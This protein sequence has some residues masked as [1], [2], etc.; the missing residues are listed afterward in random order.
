MD[1][2]ASPRRVGCQSD[3]FEVEERKATK[4]AEDLSLISGPLN[5]L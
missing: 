2:V 3:R 5:G 1:T 4:L